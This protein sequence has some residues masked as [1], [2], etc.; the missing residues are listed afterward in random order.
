MYF[1]TKII[2]RNVNIIN[3]AYTKKLNTSY[4]NNKKREKKHNS[5]YAI[6]RIN[7]LRNIENLK[8][9]YLKLQNIIIFSI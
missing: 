6:L 3:Q 4:V 5:K 7:T 1:F 2:Y 9:S 8:K